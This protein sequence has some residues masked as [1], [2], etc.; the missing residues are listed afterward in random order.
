MF[1][2]R[3]EKL[4]VPVDGLPVKVNLCIV[5]SLWKIARSVTFPGAK[6]IASIWNDMRYSEVRT[7][8]MILLL[9]RLTCRS[10]TVPT[11]HRCA[12]KQSATHA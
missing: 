11:S 7:A 3:G 4:Y 8:G 1:N 12:A 9:S 2:A 5:H 10:R 6:T